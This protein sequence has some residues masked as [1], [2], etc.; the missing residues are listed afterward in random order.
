[1]AADGED[2]VDAS[3]PSGNPEAD[4]IDRVLSGELGKSPVE[5]PKTGKAGGNP[6]QQAQSTAQIPAMYNTPEETD[7]PESPDD[8]DPDPTPPIQLG[9]KPV[10][11]LDEI[12]GVHR[13]V[14]AVPAEEVSGVELDIF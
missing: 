1:V 10:P 3:I 13:G 14:A 6:V 5:A 8:L 11:K 2:D 9:K 4:H 12:P 7:S